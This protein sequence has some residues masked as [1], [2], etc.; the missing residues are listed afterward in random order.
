MPA[1]PATQP[2]P[3]TGMRFTSGRRPSRGT[4]RASSDGAAIP[5]TDTDI[6]RSTSSG[7]SPTSARALPTA[8]TPSSVP[9]RMKTSFD[10]PNPSRSGY[11][12]SGSARC[13]ERTPA[14]AWNLREAAPGSRVWYHQRTERLGDLVLRV[15]MLGQCAGHR[16]DARHAAIVARVSRARWTISARLN[17][18]CDLV[19]VHGCRRWLS[20][21]GGRRSVGGRQE[22]GRTAGRRPAGAGSSPR[23]TGSTPRRTWRRWCPDTRWTTRT[24]WPWLASIAAWI[25][26]QEAAGLSSVVACSSLR[27]RYRDALATGHPSVSFCLL[28]ADPDAR[29]SAQPPARAFHASQPADQP[30]LGARA[31]R[32]WRTR[33]DRGVDRSA[34]RRGRARRGGRCRRLIDRVG[35]LPPVRPR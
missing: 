28:V 23:A 12:S 16:D 17:G 4:S 14:A 1:A 29:G 35:A 3:K 25:G 10:A 21:A 26:G 19:R 7:C 20:H 24:W 31:A 5:V 22:H 13:R 27:R 30:A 34:C 18:G 33:L 2:S 8:C 6:S 32:A 11:S 15:A 9:T